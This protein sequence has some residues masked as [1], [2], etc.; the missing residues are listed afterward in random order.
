MIPKDSLLPVKTQLAGDL[1]LSIALAVDVLFFKHDS[2]YTKI[3]SWYIERCCKATRRMEEEEGDLFYYLFEFIS[4]QLKIKN[5]YQ[6][7]KIDKRNK[8]GM[9]ILIAYCFRVGTP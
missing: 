1:L 5:S 7:I 9:I 6:L 4:C 2:F 8:C 3:A